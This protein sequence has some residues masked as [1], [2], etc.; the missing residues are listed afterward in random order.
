MNNSKKTICNLKAPTFGKSSEKVLGI[1]IM[2][3]VYVKK[4]KR[5]MTQGAKR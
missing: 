3:I 2:T 1:L 5:F 4:C